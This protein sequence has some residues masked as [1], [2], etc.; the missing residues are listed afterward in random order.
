MN[1]LDCVAVSDD[2]LVCSYPNELCITN[3]KLIDNCFNVNKDDS[4]IFQCKALKTCL[5]FLNHT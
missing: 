2:L 1:Y 5:I 4:L 3:A